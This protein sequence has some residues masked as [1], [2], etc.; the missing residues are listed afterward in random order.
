M[1]YR[2]YSFQEAPWLVRPYRT[3][4]I[5][6]L[7]PRIG[8]DIIIQAQTTGGEKYVKIISPQVMDWSKQEQTE[9]GLWN[10]EKFRE[11]VE[12]IK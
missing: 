11:T 1:A 12:T 3:G 8:D 7:K 2:D 9:F 6:V 4:T 10:W 5:R